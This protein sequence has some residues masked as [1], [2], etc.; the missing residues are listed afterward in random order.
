MDRLIQKHAVAVNRDSRIGRL[1]L[2]IRFCRLL[3]KV[4][5]R[6]FE[7]TGLEFIPPDNGVI[8]CANHVN[9]L[10]DVV[11]VQAST[12]RQ[13]RPLA[14]SGLFENFLL[15]P[16]LHAI[17]AVPVYRRQDQ[18]SAMARNN[19]SFA[20][21]HELLELNEILIIFPEGQSHSDSH[22]HDLKTGAARIALGAQLHHGQLPVVIPVGLTFSRKGNF[23]G[24]VLVQFADPVEMTVP[25]DTRQGN[26]V[27]LLTERIRT[28]LATVTLNAPSWEDID[29]ATR[30]EN[31]FALRH[32]KCRHEKLQQ[33]FL[34]LQRLLDGKRLLL[35]HEP[36]KVRALISHL[37]M[38]ERLCKCCGI[39]DYHLTL[40][41]KP[42]L[43][44]LYVLRTLVVLFIGLPLML[45]GAINS[46]MPFVLTGL[47]STRIARGLDQYDTSKI[48]LGMLLFGVFW[49]LQ[50]AWVFYMFGGQW[51][52]VYATSLL[53][54]TPVA[55]ALRHELRNILINLKVFIMFLRKQQ[56]RAYLKT[57]RQEIEA[58][59][60]HMVRIAKRLARADEASPAP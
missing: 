48:L 57:R 18:G 51:T 15:R 44:A 58:E 30:V 55:V 36:D 1:A 38:F 42:A 34:A 16:L 19:E 40:N 46:A 60:A 43:I 8:L 31:F 32:G 56:L 13:I 29:L 5:Y 21:C 10:V 33:R 39:S 2:W 59:L 23:R 37:R 9:A 22:L 26:A 50:T 35:V 27:A 20:K 28:G 11:V 12:D 6:R 45:W 47:L 14:R 3:T 52:I 7:V 49:A 25:T 17:G 54:S 41:Y 53:V 4:F 24:D